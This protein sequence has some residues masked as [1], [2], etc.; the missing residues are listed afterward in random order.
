M[1]L[2][3]YVYLKHVECKS[4]IRTLVNVP[5]H[6]SWLTNERIFSITSKLLTWKTN[7]SSGLFAI[8]WSSDWTIPSPTPIAKRV[9]PSSLALSAG[10]RTASDDFPSVTTIPTRGTF[11][12]VFLAPC[13]SPNRSVTIVSIA[14]PVFVPPPLYLEITKEK[15][16]LMSKNNKYFQN[17]VVIKLIHNNS[18]LKIAVIR[19]LKYQVTVTDP[20]K[21][22]RR[23]YRNGCPCKSHS[24]YC[25][26]FR[27][28]ITWL[29]DPITWHFNSEKEKKNTKT[30]KIK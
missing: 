10:P 14:D 4:M 16:K 18:M 6:A 11:S 7:S 21:L 15:K 27:L 2:R 17:N 3:F 20:N 8:S 24:G 23:A 5:S 29:T 1:N 26:L 9:I 30:K 28:N 22:K 25:D 19:E 13:P 12:S